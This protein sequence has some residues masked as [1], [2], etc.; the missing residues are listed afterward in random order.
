MKNDIDF[1]GITSYSPQTLLGPFNGNG[2]SIKN[3]VITSY[4][5]EKTDAVRH[6]TSL[7]L[8]SNSVNISNLV[9]NNVHI[10]RLTYG[11]TYDDIV[12]ASPLL[13]NGSA[14][15]TNI[16][17]QGCSVTVIGNENR[18]SIGGLAGKSLDLVVINCLVNDFTVEVRIGGDGRQVG[19]LIGGVAG[20]VGTA[21]ITTTDADLTLN[22]DA[23]FHIIYAAA[24][25]GRNTG[26]LTVTKSVAQ[27]IANTPFSAAAQ[28]SGVVGQS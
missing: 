2:F 5:E 1:T 6:Y 10:N 23:E 19:F 24:V 7:F 12:Y 28:L 3:L 17:L 14:I 16:T 13:A 8:T 25:V 20:T 15:L 11:A 27:L 26:K 4:V 21:S 22:S 18:R 9:L